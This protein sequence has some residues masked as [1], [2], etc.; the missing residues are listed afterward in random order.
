MWAYTG[1]EHYTK[2]FRFIEGYNKKNK[3]RE[4]IGYDFEKYC[5]SLKKNYPENLNIIATSNW[6]LNNAKKKLFTER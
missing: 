3:P 6:Q 2:S 5:W 1:S 4:L